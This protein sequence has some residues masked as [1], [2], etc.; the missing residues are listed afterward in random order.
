MAGR[1]YWIAA[2]GCS[3]VAVHFDVDT[4]DSD[5][6]VPGLGAEPGGLTGAQARRIVADLDAAVDVVAFTVAEFI[7]R[8][9]ISLQQ[10]L[11]GFPLISG[12]VSQVGWQTRHGG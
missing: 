1:R 4:I 12:T 7:P 3:R 10:F 8:Q 6:I 5:E 9:V 2:T 11:T